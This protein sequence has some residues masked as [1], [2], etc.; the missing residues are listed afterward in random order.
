MNDTPIKT[1]PL[2]QRIS[3]SKNG[4]QLIPDG[5]LIAAAESESDQ[6]VFN[7]LERVIEDL[8]ELSRADDN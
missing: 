6:Q 4:L 2:L 7:H 8:A 1:E 3:D 5:R